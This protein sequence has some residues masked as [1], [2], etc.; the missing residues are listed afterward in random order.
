MQV[1]FL[2]L[3]F[4]IGAS[5]GSFLCCQARRLHLK[6]S[7][8]ESL[9][10]RSVCLSCKKQLKWY[11]NIPLFSWLLLR[12]KCRFCHHKIGIAEFI[13]E[14][15]MGLAFFIFG[16]NTQL[17]ALIHYPLGW[18]SFIATLVFILILAYLAIYDGIYGELPT[19]WL[20]IAI[21]YAVGLTSYTIF[22]NPNLGSVGHQLIQITW[23][24]LIL[25]G[26]YS[27]LY[28]AS[29]GK[30]VGDGDWLL[31]TAIAIALANP[32]LSLIT[33]FLTNFLALI[34]A[35]PNLKKSHQI[36][37]GPSMV[38]AFIITYTFSNFFLQMI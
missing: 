19:T 36:H 21:I 31:A 11:D 33:L 37:L 29:K 24:V 5:L 12:G 35:I 3:L 9:G 10:A 27:L 20:I 1:L 30:W 8:H 25:G 22:Q 7:R 15:S 32:W 23:S 28:L 38:A 13:S 2:I 6:A 26:L 14:L 16:L 4:I 18:I 34:F 17:E